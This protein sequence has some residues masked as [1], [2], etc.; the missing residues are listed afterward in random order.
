MIMSEKIK[1]TF[2]LSSLDKKETEEDRIGR[3][4]ADDD[5]R[6]SRDCPCRDFLDPRDEGDEGKCIILQQIVKVAKPCPVL[7]LFWAFRLDEKD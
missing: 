4:E 6:C 7:R 2:D 1:I 5:G 3:W